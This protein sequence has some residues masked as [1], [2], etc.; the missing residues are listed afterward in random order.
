MTDELP[1]S[2]QEAKAMKDGNL[3]SVSKGVH[4][5][6]PDTVPLFTTY[7]S[8]DL[9]PSSRF[10]GGMKGHGIWNQVVERMR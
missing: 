8:T 4:F 7:Q 6:F 10:N 2:I 9:F 3:V 5:H 1:R